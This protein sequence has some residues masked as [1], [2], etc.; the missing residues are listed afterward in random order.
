MPQR[1]IHSE[2]FSPIYASVASACAGAAGFGVGFETLLRSA[3]TAI[4]ALFWEGA[5]WDLVLGC[6]ARAGWDCCRGVA[7]GG[8]HARQAFQQ[9][10]DEGCGRT[11]GRQVDGDP[12]FQLDDTGGDLDQAEA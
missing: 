10:S 2:R 3:K 8:R 1:S 4:A 5:A 12:G 6:G 9:E 7:S 11:G